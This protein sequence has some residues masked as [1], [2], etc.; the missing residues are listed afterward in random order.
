MQS[1][2]IKR[3][4]T[5]SRSRL[6]ADRVRQYP[7]WYESKNTNTK[8]NTN[9]NTNKNTNTNTNTNTKTNTITNTNTTTKTN[10]NT[11]ST[12]AG[13]NSLALDMRAPQTILRNQLW[14][15]EQAFSRYDL[16]G[17]SWQVHDLYLCLY[18]ICYNTC[19]C[20][21]ERWS[22]AR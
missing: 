12:T 17:H 21:Y 10:T 16:C 14:L 5:L 9:T 7:T 13:C 22:Q 15:T 19:I 1:E 3:P 6:P 8:T 4:L 18:F 11:Y 2:K 20:I